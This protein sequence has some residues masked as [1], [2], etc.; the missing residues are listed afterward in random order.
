MDQNIGRTYYEAIVTIAEDTNETLAG[1]DLLL[2]IPVEAY[3]KTDERAPLSYSVQRL[4]VYFA[5]AFCEE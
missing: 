5:R 4:S 2:E 1:L 3:I